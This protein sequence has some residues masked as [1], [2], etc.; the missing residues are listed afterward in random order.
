[1]LPQR[2]SIIKNHFK[3]TAWQRKRPDRE[4]WGGRLLSRRLISSRI[5]TKAWQRGTWWRSCRRSRRFMRIRNRWILERWG[6]RMKE[7]RIE[8]RKK[9]KIS[10]W[11][12]K[13]S[14]SR[15]CKRRLWR[16][17]LIGIMRIRIILRR[18]RRTPPST[19]KCNLTGKKSW[20]KYRKRRCWRTSTRIMITRSTL[21]Q[22]DLGN[23]TKGIRL[24]RT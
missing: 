6:V 8:K 18:W 17:R 16:R 14:G 3:M 13:S 12:G 1:M 19:S 22:K 20:R 4:E 11:R 2:I 7:V 21:V 10:W 5:W 23:C 24:P 15:K 9:R